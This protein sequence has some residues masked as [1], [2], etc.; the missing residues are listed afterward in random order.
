MFMS[1]CYESRVNP[2]TKKKKNVAR[3]IFAVSKSD[4]VFRTSSLRTWR[5]I[6][7]S[8]TK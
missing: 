6:I 7:A 8:G 4:L 5:T 1:L 3:I 2:F